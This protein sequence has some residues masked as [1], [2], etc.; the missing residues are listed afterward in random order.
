MYNTPAMMSTSRPLNTQKDNTNFST[1]LT[2][3]APSKRKE[4]KNASDGPAAS[5]RSRRS[6]QSKGKEFGSSK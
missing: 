2:N 3:Q 5:K 1:P 4:V 6:T